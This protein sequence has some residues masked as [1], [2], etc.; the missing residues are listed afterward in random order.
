M[1]LVEKAVSLV[2]G[3]TQT[4]PVVT[5]HV[6]DPHPLNWLYITYNT[7]EELVRVDSRGNTIPAA[8]SRYDWVDDRTLEIR[9][10]ENEVFPDGEALTVH[11]VKRAFDEMIQWKAPHPPGTHFNHD[12]RTTL[13]VVDEHTVRMHFPEP[14]GLAT[15]KIRAMH[16]MNTAFW[17]ECGFGYKKNGSGEGHW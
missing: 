6:V 1:N 10:R 2:A 7:V 14:D 12:P 17:R 15:G 5:I 9:V 4:A 11:T 3:K 13:E 16:L 8:A